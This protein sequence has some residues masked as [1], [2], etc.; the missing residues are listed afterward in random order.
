[1]RVEAW[2][3]RPFALDVRRKVPKF[4]GERPSFPFSDHRPWL[5]VVVGRWFLF[6]GWWD[7]KDNDGNN[8]KRLLWLGRPQKVDRRSSEET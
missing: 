7:R 1:M 8:Y 3:R 6:V 4:R 2:S 5:R